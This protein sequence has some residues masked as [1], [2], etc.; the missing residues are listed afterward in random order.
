M[1]QYPLLVPKVITD[2][3]IEVSQQGKLVT[4]DSGFHIVIKVTVE[5]VHNLVAAQQSGYISA[6]DC[7]M[8]KEL[9]G[10]WSLIYHS[11]M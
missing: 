6:D 3:G 8:I 10:K 2:S 1:C 5:A 9:R 4:R 11:L 7:D